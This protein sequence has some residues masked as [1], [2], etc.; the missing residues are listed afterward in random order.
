MVDHEATEREILRLVEQADGH[1]RAMLLIIY[2]MHQELIANTSSTRQIAAAAEDHAQTLRQHAQDE[3]ALI[4]Q[5]RGGWR[6]ATVAF[7]VITALLGALQAMA[8]REI[9]MARDT[10]ATNTN[11]IY[12]LEAENGIQKDQLWSIRMKLRLQEAN[13]DKQ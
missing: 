4:N 3:M 2:R 8:M 12:A 9:N 6:A 7:G 5:I 13:G 1:D 10:I 11:R